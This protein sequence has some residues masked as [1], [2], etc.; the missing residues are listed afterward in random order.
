M[1]IT[2]KQATVVN[3]AFF[4]GFTISGLF[5]DDPKLYYTCFKDIFLLI[6]CTVYPAALLIYL[7][8][9]IAGK[10]IQVNNTQPPKY[11]REFFETTVCF[12]MVAAMF[13]WPLKKYRQGRLHNYV[14][15]IE[16]STPGSGIIGNLIYLIISFLVV[17]LVTYWK[18]RLLHTKTFFIFH[19][20]HHQFHDPTPI[21]AFAVS[22]VEAFLTFGL[23]LWD[24]L[25]LPPIFKFYFPLHSS[26]IIGFTVLNL[27]LHAGYTLNILEIILPRLF[28]NSS[29]FH[30]VHHAKGNTHFGELLTLWD[31]IMGTGQTFYTPVAKVKE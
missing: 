30:N 10:R 22:P 31:W 18:H 13:A 14:W 15:D 2:A 28:I 26:I 7:Y 1:K 25:P 17:D 6:V 21:G 19:A 20:T 3:W 4:I 29:G 5:G 9:L 24:C 12:W 23:G 27:Y 11:L 8:C 16:E